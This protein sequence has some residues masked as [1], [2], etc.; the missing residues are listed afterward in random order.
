MVAEEGIDVV[1]PKP[2]IILNAANRNSGAFD[3][4]YQISTEPSRSKNC[5]VASVMRLQSP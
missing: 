5:V 1:F 3:H 2:G 4:V